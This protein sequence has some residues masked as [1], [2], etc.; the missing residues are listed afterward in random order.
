M[1]I[2]EPNRIRRGAELAVYALALAL[3]GALIGAL[4]T[5]FLWWLP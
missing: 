5:L 3:S 2:T 4:V 1:K